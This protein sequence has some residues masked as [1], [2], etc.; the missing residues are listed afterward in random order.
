MTF[1]LHTTHPSSENDIGTL[2]LAIEGV[3]ES[4][5]LFDTVETERAE[6]DRALL[7]H[8]ALLFRGWGLESLDDF[9]RFVTAFSGSED[10]FGYAGGA[11]PR[12]ALG[13][14]GLYSSTEYPASMTLSLHN[15]LSYAGVWPRRLFFFCLVEPEKG[16]ATTLADSRRILA[17]LDPAVVEEFRARGLLYIRNL[18][19]LKGSGY[20][21]QEALETDDSAE[22]EARCRNIGAE[23][24]WRE[25][26]V[27]R[28]RQRLPATR[29]HPETG[30]EV[31]FNQ[32]DGFHPSVLDPAT[33][34]EQLALCGSEAHFRLN[35][36]FG[37]GTPIDPAALAHIRTVLGAQ[38]VPHRWQVGDVVVLDN[39]L[40]AHGRA[41]FEGP[42][43]I[44]LAM[45]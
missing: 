11:S 37:D 6:F 36:A 40:A 19:P 7:G 41:P 13:G 25:G 28:M 34:A 16:G 4:T 23:Y 42:R 27:L 2:P 5:A 14:R 44:A 38:T 24:E 31:W 1:L 22:A 32:A 39:M 45:T 18:S 12:Q 20:S 35:V 29:V 33:Y 17:A 26:G 21:W 8:G 3:G 15:E 43:K 30:E 9:A 10:R